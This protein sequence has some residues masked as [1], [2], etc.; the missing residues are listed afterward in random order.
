MDSK[1][2]RKTTTL[3]VLGFWLEPHQR[4]DDPDFAGALGRGLARF[5]RFHEARSVDLSGIADVE[6]RESVA[7]IVEELIT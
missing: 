6:L 2:D 3:H 5:A 7:E 4:T 1:L